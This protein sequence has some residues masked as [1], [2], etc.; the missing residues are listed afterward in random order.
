V[1]RDSTPN[2]PPNGLKGTGRPDWFL[3]TAEAVKGYRPWLKAAV[4]TVEVV[5]AALLVVATFRTI[6]AQHQL[7]DLQAATGQ[8]DLRILQ[9]YTSTAWVYDNPYPC[10]VQALVKV[11]NVGLHD[12]AV[13][14]VENDAVNANGTVFG[15]TA[16][17]LASDRFIGNT[18]R[19]YQDA[20]VEVPLFSTTIRSGEIAT[21][22]LDFDGLQWDWQ[23]M[24][25]LR[26]Q[27][28]P[29]LGSASET[30]V[31]QDPDQGSGS[32]SGSVPN[33]CREPQAPVLHRGGEP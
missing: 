4:V 32:L 19:P 24:R 33:A 29:V 7:T 23:S 12:S 18:T 11:A 31:I 25:E 3:R 26:I 21:F 16:L 8:A 17:P 9:A 1:A 6:E 15:W 5:L 10:Y 27:V 14:R 30:W 13:L 2:P 20:R 22:L 28:I